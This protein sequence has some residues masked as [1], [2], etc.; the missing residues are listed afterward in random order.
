MVL[1]SG[2]LVLAFLADPAGTVLREIVQWVVYGL[3]ILMAPLVA[4]IL[5]VVQFLR[6]LV[7]QRRESLPLTATATAGPDT[8]PVPDALPGFSDALLTIPAIILLL[9]PIIMLLMV[10]LFAHR[11][12]SRT[13]L[14]AGEQRESIFSWGA[15]G[16]D[17]ADFLRGLRRPGGEAGL[18]GALRRLLAEDPATRIRRRYVQLLLKGEAAG[19][20]RPVH[21]TPHEFAPML[22]QG[23]DEDQAIDAL[24]GFYERARYAPAT[25]DD[26]AAD[27]ADR[28][29]ETL[30]RE[31]PP[32]RG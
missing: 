1:M 20:Q 18:R 19:R 8:A 13:E 3:V 6:Q 25:V 4:I 17:L 27:E 32:R 26:T 16:T 5:M 22:A 12:R 10:I 31:E 24:T 30:N 7:P 14:E 2:L 15:L 28:V 23:P 29:W 11:R 9:L 21:Q